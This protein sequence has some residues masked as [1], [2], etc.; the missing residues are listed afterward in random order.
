MQGGLWLR[1]VFLLCLKR[2]IA[3]AVSHEGGAGPASLANQSFWAG[4]CEPSNQ[5]GRRGAPPCLVPASG[6]RNFRVRVRAL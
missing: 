1:S 5:N 6:E 2:G 3:R 4:L